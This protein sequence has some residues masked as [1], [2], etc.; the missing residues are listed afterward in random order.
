MRV[1]GVA[2]QQVATQHL[3]SWLQIA[4]QSMN[5]A[6]REHSSGSRYSV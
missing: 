6:T 3:H 4:K 1:S 5:S 2:R